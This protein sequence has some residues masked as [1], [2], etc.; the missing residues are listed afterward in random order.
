M[1][2]KKDNN[3]QLDGDLSESHLNSIL[4]SEIKLEIF[5]C[6]I[7]AK[8]K[9]AQVKRDFM[10]HGQL[11]TLHGMAKVHLENLKKRN[12]ASARNELPR[13]ADI[14]V[15]IEDEM[16]YKYDLDCFLLTVIEFQV[17]IKV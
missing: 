14:E 7:L 13:I 4:T 6:S 9:E 5:I 15:G 3:E 16:N 10:Y 11:S 2:L 17:Q 12:E 8:I 1:S